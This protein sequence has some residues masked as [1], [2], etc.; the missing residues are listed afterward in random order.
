MLSRRNSVVS[1]RLQGKK[2]GPIPTARRPSTT[3]VEDIL[4]E[5]MRL[6]EEVQNLRKELVGSFRGSNKFVS[7]GQFR[8]DAKSQPQGC[9]NCMM[10]RN[11]VKRLKGENNG[12]RGSI[13]AL[14]SQLSLIQDGQTKEESENQVRA[15]S[16]MRLESTCKALE[17][18]L[19]SVRKRMATESATRQ[20]M[21]KQSEDTDKKMDTLKAKTSELEEDNGK[22]KKR[23]E[24]R[25]KEI[26]DLRKRVEEAVKAHDDAAREAE[27]LKEKV[28][29]VEAEVKMAKKRLDAA[30]EEH[31]RAKSLMSGDAEK[32]RAAI[33]LLKKQ[34]QHAEKEKADA[35]KE[36]ARSKARVDEQAKLKD[37]VSLAMLSSKEKAMDLERSLKDSQEGMQ[38]AQ[39]QANSRLKLV[40]ILEV[41]N[42]KLKSDMNTM[43]DFC[44]R[45]MAQISAMKTAIQAPM[46]M[47]VIAPI[48]N[49]IFRAAGL[50]PQ[51]MAAA[52]RASLKNNKLDMSEADKEEEAIM[53][54][55]PNIPYQDIRSFVEERIM[56]RYAGLYLQADKNKSPDGQDSLD[57]WVQTTISSMTEAIQAKIASSVDKKEWHQKSD[58]KKK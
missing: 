37:E 13:A 22:L 5:N 58:D 2:P 3:T 39:D 26:E 40:K 28:R 53:R 54:I 55:L 35:E 11:S 49:V 21:E 9:A 41:E 50:S 38:K 24:S 20:A 34:L 45:A 44:D 17:D 30:V 43:R 23:L 52:R 15:D 1:P 8:M 56:P 25:K 18:E 16:V 31:E 12:L 51:M 33:E 27:S 10:F 57:D 32:D 19:K 6:Q 4:E 48:V 14:E 7:G 42:E 29:S 47:C 36:A 46:H